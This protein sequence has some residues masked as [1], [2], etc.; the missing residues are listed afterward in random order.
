LPQKPKQIQER[1]IDV[2]TL[3]RLDEAK[4]IDKREV[5]WWQLGFEG[6]QI[7]SE[8]TFNQSLTQI[9]YKC[10]DNRSQFKDYTSRSNRTV[11]NRTFKLW[12]HEYIP[13][14]LKEAILP[15]GSV[16]TLFIT[17]KPINRNLLKYQIERAQPPELI[18]EPHVRGIAITND[19]EFLFWHPISMNTTAMIGYNRGIPE[20]VNLNL[21][22]NTLLY[23]TAPYEF[24]INLIRKERSLKKRFHKPPKEIKSVEGEICIVPYY[25]FD[26]YETAVTIYPGKAPLSELDIPIVLQ[27]NPIIGPKIIGAGSLWEDRD[28]SKSGTIYY[29]GIPARYIEGIRLS[30]EQRLGLAIGL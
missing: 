14:V 3:A 6:R 2:R 10:S 20:Q 21:G 26:P 25:E 18:M 16:A 17:I 29:W 8:E 4:I 7:I 9:R 22:M 27:G 28:D 24:Y 1:N 23:T 19:N 12:F 15:G 13:I 30:I 11:L 5:L